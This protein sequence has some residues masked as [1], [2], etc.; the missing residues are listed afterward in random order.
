MPVSM[1]KSNHI[2]ESVSEHRA[3]AF[4]DTGTAQKEGGQHQFGQWSLFPL[5]FY[6]GLIEACVCRNT[7][8]RSHRTTA[9]YVHLPLCLDNSVKPLVEEASLK[10]LFYAQS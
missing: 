9:G 8:E 3:D 7:E 6:C 5:K 2:K 10:Q 4:W 1:V